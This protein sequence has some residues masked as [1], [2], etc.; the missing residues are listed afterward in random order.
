MKS[1][2]ADLKNAEKNRYGG[3]SKA[4]AYLEFFIDKNRNWVHLDIAG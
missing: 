3:A 2:F 1:R 4:A